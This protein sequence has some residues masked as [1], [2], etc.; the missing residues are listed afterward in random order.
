MEKPYVI[1]ASA[2]RHGVDE[3][4]M[5]HAVRNSIRIDCQDDGTLMHVGPARPGT[6]ILEVGVIMWHGRSAIIH[7]MKARKKFL[8]GR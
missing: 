7:A 2:R 1:L 8:P 6:P 3:D 5:T 4:D